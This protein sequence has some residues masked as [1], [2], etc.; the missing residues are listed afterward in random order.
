MKMHIYVPYRCV[1]C[2]KWPIILLRGGIM[3]EV[4]FINSTNVNL[5]NVVTY[6]L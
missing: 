1:A 5:Q 2:M 3:A 4:N 6:G